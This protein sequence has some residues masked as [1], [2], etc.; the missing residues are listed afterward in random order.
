MSTGQC[1]NGTANICLS[2]NF[3]P[4]DPGIVSVFIW[5]WEVGIWNRYFSLLAQAVFRIQLPG[6]ELLI[7]TCMPYCTAMFFAPVKVAAGLPGSIIVLMNY[8]PHAACT[9]HTGVFMCT[10]CN[11]QVWRW[12]DWSGVPKAWKI[13]LGNSETG[14]LWRATLTLFSI[15]QKNPKI[16]FI[17]YFDR[18]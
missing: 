12:Q 3:P 2:Y 5:L 16:L 7:Q 18:S 11:L 14:G 8:I 9:L 4:G 17:L 10:W 6:L 1:T 15:Q 13:W